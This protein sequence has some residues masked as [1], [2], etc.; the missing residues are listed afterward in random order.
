MRDAPLSPFPTVASSEK[1]DVVAAR[2]LEGRIA[3][4]VNGSPFVLTVPYI[5]AEIGQANK[6]YY[7]N[8]IYA[9]ANRLMR[10]IAVFERFWRLPFICP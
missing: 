5:I 4:I 6:D 3:L 10:N 2:L 9:S 1:P 7:S 8:F